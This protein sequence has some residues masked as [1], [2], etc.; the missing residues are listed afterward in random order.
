MTIGKFITIEGGEGT[1]KST[2]IK[3][4]L[5]KLKTEGLEVIETREP[6]GSIGAEKIRELVIGGNTDNWDPISEI[7]LLCAARRH[8]MK[9]VILPALF[10]GKWVICDRF[11][12][13]SM[14]YQ[15]I[16]QGLGEARINN[17]SEFTLEGF[18]PDLTLV[19]D[20]PVEVGLK[21]AKS[22][23]INKYERMDLS[24]HNKIRNAF[25]KIAAQNPERCVLIDAEAD[26]KTITDEAWGVIKGRLLEAL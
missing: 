1:G 22:V 6:G 8:H 21:R 5:K 12:D 14:A 4:L 16:A 2:Q 7:L 23:E 25:I 13:S 19:F 20:I 26:I 24:F 3:R 9:E 10:E 17:L 18:M 15:G 11:L